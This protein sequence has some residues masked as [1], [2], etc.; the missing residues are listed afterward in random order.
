MIVNPLFFYLMS[1]CNSARGVTI[2]L[3]IVSGLAILIMTICYFVA[4]YDSCAEEEDLAPL[5]KAIIV[6]VRICVVS[7][8]CAILIPSENTLLLMQAA[9]L[10]TTDNVNAIFEALKAAIDYATTVLK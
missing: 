10:A 1:V 3:S 5:K 2:T 6:S 4:K 9:K 7:L 8:V